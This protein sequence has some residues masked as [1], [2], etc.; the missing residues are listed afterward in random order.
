[1]PY[2]H[3]L[4]IGLIPT[5]EQ[6]E[7]IYYLV[8][9]LKKEFDLTFATEPGVSIPHLTLFQGVYQ[10]E[11]QVIDATTSLD[12]SQ[13]SRYQPIKGVSIWAQKILFLDCERTPSLYHAHLQV[14]E[15]LF[16]LCEGKSADPQN[17]I[18]ITED[19]QRSFNETG[20]P[21]SRQEYLPH[22]TLAHLRDT[23]LYQNPD[24]QR[25]L[26]RLLEE[27]SLINGVNFERLVVYRVGPLGACKEF[28][29]ER[30]L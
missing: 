23:T 20:Y 12:L 21:F 5:E 28:A 4:G 30:T 25:Q 24:T 10:D 13:V 27:T 18:D 19:Q 17:F 15:K 16:P 22:F 29:Y 9:S 8:D 7:Q 14:F 3:R 6:Q 1:M 11:A 2:V 26:N